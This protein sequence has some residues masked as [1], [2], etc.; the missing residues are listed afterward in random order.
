MG[1]RDP[2]ILWSSRATHREAI[3]ETPFRMTYDTEA[4]ILLEVQMRSLELEHFNEKN[5]K[6][7]R[8]SLDTINKVH[9]EAL[10]RL[11]IQ[12][13]MVVWKYNSKVKKKNFHLG[14]LVLRK[15]EFKASER[16]E[17]KLGAN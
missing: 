3:G 9:D 5:D 6:G 7:I 2:G 8:L 10:S 15:T 17:E 12:K 1:W 13:Q 11:V 14:D 16:Q 4:V